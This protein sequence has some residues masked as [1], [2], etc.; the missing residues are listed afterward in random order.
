LLIENYYD[1]AN[2]ALT[3]KF[4]STSMGRRVEKD[5]PVF[6]NIVPP[7]AD[8][9]W[10]FDDKVAEGTVEQFDYAAEGARVSVNR[11]VFNADNELIDERTFVSNYIPWPNVFRYGPGVEPGDYS[12]VPDPDA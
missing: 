2:E 11:R 6:E 4:Y 12:L 8:D 7:P 3:F 9:V 1:T 5:E 10:E